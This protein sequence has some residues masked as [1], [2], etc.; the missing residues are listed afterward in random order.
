MTQLNFSTTQKNIQDLANHFESLDSKTQAYASELDHLKQTEVTLQGLESYDTVMTGIRA[1][2]NTITEKQDKLLAQKIQLLNFLDEVAQFEK[3]V[4]MT[5]STILENTTT[6]APKPF[7]K[8]DPETVF[9]AVGIKEPLPTKTQYTEPQKI[10]N[11]KDTVTK[12]TEVWD[13]LDAKLNNP[14]Y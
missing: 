10:E 2:T 4:E 9:S 1:A 12:S 13:D 11:S 8:T 3:F 5:H 7:D 6:F 14:G